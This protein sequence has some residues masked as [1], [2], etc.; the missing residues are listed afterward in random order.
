MYKMIQL[1]MKLLLPIFI[2]ILVFIILISSVIDIYYSKT[3]SIEKLHNGIVLATYISKVL[4]ETQKE[5]G[6]SSG[7]LTNEGQKFKEE[8]LIQRKLTDQSLKEIEVFLSSTKNENIKESL[9]AALKS[10]PRLYDIR[11]K[12]SS[13]SISSEEAIFYF[14]HLNEM[15]LNVIIEIS[16]ISEL[17]SITQNIIAYSSVL[18]AKENIGHMRAV[19]VATLSQSQL[20]DSNKI[21]FANLLFIQKAYLEHFLKYVSK[22][23]EI[24]YNKIFQGKCIEELERISYMILNARSADQVDIEP[25]YWFKNSTLAINKLKDIDAY[26]EKEILFNIEEALDTTYQHFGFL[27]FLNLASSVLFVLM[28][29]ATN[30]LLKREKRLKSLIDKYIISSTTDLQGK[31]TF[32]S[33]AFAAISG[34][35]VEE[36][37]G[38]PHNIVR[39][40]DMP[41]SAFKELWSTIQAGK[42]WQGRVKN[43]TKNGGFYW[44]YVNVEPLFDNKG[45]IEGY[46]AIRLNITDSILLEEQVELEVEKNRKKDQTLLQQSRLAQMGEMISMI[47]HQWRQP[48]SAI[49]ATSATL[50]LKAKIGQLDNDEIVKK[51]HDISNFSQHLSHTIDDF[52]NFFK[53]NKE[54]KYTTYDDL[55]ASVLNIIEVSILN[56]NIQLVQELHCHKSFLTYSNELRQVILNL[57]KNAEDILIEKSIQEPFIKIET[58]EE[59]GDYILEISDNGGGIPPEISEKVFDP[60]FS[61]KTEKNGTGLG[62]YM[63]KIIIEEHCAGKLS[64]YNN[65]YGAV[66]K[67]TLK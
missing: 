1:K 47:A 13:L 21:K 57:I 9:E 2:L 55:I 39:H 41:K 62:L 25:R 64:I 5:R 28:L 18:N 19:G 58:F 51:A 54:K 50:E 11:K 31:I 24:F 67:I 8:L 27:I 52:R 16:K 65:K 63:S 66:F 7:F 36:L 17:P 3:K 38:K 20:F 43:R 35:T 26:L 37:I 59:N 53:P 30:R 60:Y 15:F 29:I 23:G 32:V 22:D 12:S 46:A 49:S 33:E 14:S 56:Q 45:K 42:I 40:P 34:Y 6:L 44:V 10:L 48:L 61:T 4:H